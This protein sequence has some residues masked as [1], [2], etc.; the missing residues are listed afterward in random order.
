MN[1]E[2]NICV[3]CDKEK[4]VQRQYLHAKNKQSRG[5]GFVFFYYCA[6]CGLLEQIIYS[7]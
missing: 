6:D 4:S 7:L 1:T 5:N 2:N 3:F